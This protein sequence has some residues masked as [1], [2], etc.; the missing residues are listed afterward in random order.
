MCSRTL[1][2]VHMVVSELIPA[3]P[4]CT[5]APFTMTGATG[6]PTPHTLRVTAARSTPDGTQTKEVADEP[7]CG[8]ETELRAFFAV[9]AGAE[10]PT[11]NQDP[12]GALH[13]LAFIEAALESGGRPVDLAALAPVR[14]PA[15]APEPGL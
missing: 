13:D 1:P 4:A 5:A 7:L 3:M 9:L 11:A 10:P 6:W 2:T 12:R 14:P 8:V 15:R